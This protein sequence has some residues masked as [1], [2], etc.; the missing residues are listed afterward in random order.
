MDINRRFFLKIAGLTGG[1]LLSGGF[2]NAN[3]DSSNISLPSFSG[4][5]IDTTMC[6]GCRSC[7]VAC[8]EA[9]KL[10]PPKVP[11]DDESVFNKYRDTEPDVY[12]VLNRYPNPKDPKNPIFVRRQC[13]HCNQPACASACL[14][15]AMEKTKEGPVFYNKDKC[16]G[17]RYCM[18]ACPFNIPK[19]EYDK[20]MPYVRKCTFCYHRQ[21][22]GKIPACA[23][24]CPTGATK[25][26]KRKELI[27]IAKIRIYQNPDKYFHHIYGESEVGGS[28][29]LYLSSVP[30]EQI[31]FRTDLGTIPY[32]EL[33]KGFLYGVP[34][35]LLLWPTFLLG[36]S[37]ANGGKTSK[38][39]LLY[40]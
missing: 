28:G 39:G 17:C 36:I 5:L 11:F 19:F 26:G 33:T 30:F 2:K 16:M 40:E 37:H 12:T 7:E 3:A 23:E 22:E 10:P 15:K 8:N 29:W 18:I 20:A 31:G 4:M 14:V 9:N 13:M 27:E 35:V 25:F 1:T 24:A 6:I 34:I 21:K 32:P 38:G